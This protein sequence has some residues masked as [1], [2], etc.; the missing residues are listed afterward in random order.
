MFY[1]IEVYWGP[2]VSISW[3]RVGYGGRK[4]LPATVQ[5]FLSLQEETTSYLTKASCLVKYF[6]QQGKSDITAYL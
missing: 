2:T 3:A 5:E 4:L 1:I 6:H